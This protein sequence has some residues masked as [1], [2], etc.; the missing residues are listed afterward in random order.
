M[1]LG[2]DDP[3]PAALRSQLAQFRADKDEFKRRVARAQRDILDRAMIDL[4]AFYRDVLSVQQ[5]AQVDLIN[6]THTEQ[7]MQLAQT[8]TTATTLHC[9]DAITTARQHLTMNVP[10]TLALE[11]MAVALTLAGNPQN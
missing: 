7:I 3:V 4:L 5:H 11:A 10:A 2:E 9:V 1:G 8:T 6:A